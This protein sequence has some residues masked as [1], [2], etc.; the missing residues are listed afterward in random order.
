MI[1]DKRAASGTGD[2]VTRIYS[3]TEEQVCSFQAL[4]GKLGSTSLG[5]QLLR[6]AIIPD[7]SCSLTITQ[8]G[9]ADPLA[10]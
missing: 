9:R 7:E 10:A 6:A 5:N 1:G 2:S 4:Y 8:A 3:I